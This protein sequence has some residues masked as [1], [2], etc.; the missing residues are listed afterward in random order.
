M[1]LSSRK[2]NSLL[3]LLAMVG[4]V[5]VTTAYCALPMPPRDESSAA[6]GNVLPGIDVLARHDFDVLAGKRVGLITN[7]TALSREGISDIDI[8]FET[9]KCKLVALFGPEH[10]IRGT[11]DEKVASGKD[12]K[13]GLPVY[14][15]YGKTQ[16]PTPEMLKDV[17]VLVFD[18]QDIGTRFYT[19][20]GTMAKA[21]QAAK[22]NGKQ[23]VV[24]DRPNPVG[25][26][27]VEGAIPPKDLCGRNTCI[28][29]IPTRHGMTIGELAKLFNDHF[30]IGC[31][32]TVVPMENWERWMYYDQTGLLWVD[33]SPNMKTLD[34]AILYPG[35]GAGETTWISC[36]RGT[37]HPFEMYG[38]PYMDSAK[39][40]AN[41]NRRTIPGIRFVPYTFTPTAKYHKFR[42]QVCHGVYAI[43]L[44]R[45]ALDSVTAGLH[46]IQAM[47][48]TNPENYKELGGFKTETGDPTTWKKL[49]EEKMTPEQIVAGWKKDIDAFKNLRAK[50]LLYK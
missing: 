40:V 13:T 31:N 29:P 43:I 37:D 2:R 45:R 5:L 35:L 9:K 44:D 32:L 20:I 1:N 22:E 36:G 49:T 18:I 6:T 10:G 41:L 28:Y 34:G 7:R 17:D 47:Y 3:G 15:L 30:G 8:L 48:E 23:F 4:A 39:L 21:M 14:S 24:L 12:T 16:K 38:A 19:Y 26:E 25:G 50:Y 27:K 33:P 42:G 11:A 46:M